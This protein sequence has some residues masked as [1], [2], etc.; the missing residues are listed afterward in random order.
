[1]LSQDFAIGLYTVQPKSQTKSFLSGTRLSG[2]KHFSVNTQQ[3]EAM[4][5]LIIDLHKAK[6]YKTETLF[7]AC[8]I[9]D[10]FLYRYM[11][12]DLREPNLVH[13]STISLLLAAK[14]EQP[15]FPSFERMINLIPLHQR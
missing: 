4:I 1:M 12:K 10:R 7:L 6:G 8:S 3:R 11:K 13:M 2:K 5:I 15:M 9:A 14:L